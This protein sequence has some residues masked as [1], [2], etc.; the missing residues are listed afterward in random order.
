MGMWCEDV[1]VVWWGMGMGVKVEVWCGGREWG[2]GCEDGGV[3]GW[4]R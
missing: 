3:V 2:M 4:E 1:G